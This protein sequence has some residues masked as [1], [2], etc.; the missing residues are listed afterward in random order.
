MEENLWLR[1]HSVTPV[2]AVSWDCMHMLGKMYSSVHWAIMQC[3][4]KEYIFCLQPVCLSGLQ[5]LEQALE[6]LRACAW[7]GRSEWLW[8]FGFEVVLSHLVKMVDN[9]WSRG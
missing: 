3:R 8:M 6:C 2:L 1:T 9:S 7:L 4:K 5:A